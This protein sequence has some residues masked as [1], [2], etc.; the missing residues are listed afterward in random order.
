MT[1][2]GKPPNPNELSEYLQ[3][4]I[5]LVLGCRDANANVVVVDGM[6]RLYVWGFLY[7]RPNA[8]DNVNAEF[9]FLFVLFSFFS[10]VKTLLTIGGKLDFVYGMWLNLAENLT[11]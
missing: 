3:M 9:S 1:L 8:N 4:P 10:F 2:P 5:G 11:G 7:R 6:V